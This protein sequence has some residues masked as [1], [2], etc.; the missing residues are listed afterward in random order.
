MADYQGYPTVT[1]IMLSMLKK[2]T[3]IA[4]MQKKCFLGERS[5]KRYIRSLRQDWGC[6]IKYDRPNNVYTMTDSGYFDFERIG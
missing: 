1:I 6:V 4:K 2:G 5:I 3:N